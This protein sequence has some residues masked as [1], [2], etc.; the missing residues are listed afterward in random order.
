MAVSTHPNILSNNQIK[1]PDKSEAFVSL[2]SVYDVMK[3]DADCGA[4]NVQSR[5]HSLLWTSFRFYR[6]Y[7][8]SSLFFPS[9][10]FLTPRADCNIF[11]TSSFFYSSNIL[12]SSS[13]SI[14]FLLIISPSEHVF[15][16]GFLLL[17]LC[18]SKLIKISALL[19]F[20]LVK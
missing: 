2:Y 18:G 16:K 12:H 10:F 14:F 20:G 1:T 15:N 13:F 3:K 7:G 8:S 5:N 19:F 11:F 9:S 17:C 6:V 4:P